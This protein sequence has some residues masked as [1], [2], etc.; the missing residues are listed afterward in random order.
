MDRK[1]SF[2]E[3]QAHL[4]LHD[5]ALPA[6]EDYVEFDPDS[7]VPRLVFKADALLDSPPPGFDLDEAVYQEDQRQDELAFARLS[8]ATADKLSTALAEGDSWMNLPPIIRPKA[9]ADRMQANA[10]YKVRNI[11]RWGH[12]AERMATDRQYIDALPKYKPTYFLLSAGGNDMQNGLESGTFVRAFNP[13][14]PT[15]PFLTP[16]G[17]A[18]LARVGTW[19]ASMLN[20]VRTAAPKVRILLLG[21]D[22]PR[23]HVDRGK[24]IGKHLK[25][26]GYPEAD[27]DLVARSVLDSLNAILANEA[28]K[29]GCV[30]VDLRRASDAYMWIDDMH[31]GTGGFTEMTARFEAAMA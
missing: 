27:W 10:H 30:F 3:F 31:P 20:D 29:A 15:A 9:I 4:K 28:A 6:L 17:T 23:P 21:Y 25:K 2:S 8:A 1:L 19:V 26:L 12:T 11:A 7:A 5:E 18:G 16:A 24:Y 22:F 14:T 13:A